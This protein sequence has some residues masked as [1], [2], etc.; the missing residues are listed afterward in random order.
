MRRRSKPRGDFGPTRM[1]EYIPGWLGV[2]SVF[3]LLPA[4]GLA[5]TRGGEDADAA[6]ADAPGPGSEGE[7]TW[8]EE[9]LAPVEPA[10]SGYHG[11]SASFESGRAGFQLEVGEVVIPYRVMAVTALPGET[12][13]LRIG[14]SGRAEHGGS[15]D[16]V[17]RD[18]DGPL[19]GAEGRWSW[20]A[21]EEP[22]VHPLRISSV[23]HADSI[24]LNVLVLHP[25]SEIRG[26]SLNGY[27]IGEYRNGGAASVEPPPGFLEVGIRERDILVSPHFTLEQFLCKQPGSPAYLAVT[28]ALVLKL[29]AILEAVN[30]AGIDA[31]TLHVMSG[32]R[33]PHYNRAI[34]NQTDLSRHLWGDAA[35]IFID[36][37]GDGMMDDLNGD[38]RVDDRD[39]EILYR[40]VESVEGAGEP[41]VHDGGLALYRTNAVRGP[42]VHVDARGHPARW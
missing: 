13:E 20:S 38:G 27:R 3:L 26:G 16:F 35:D 25:R 2:L 42:F 18:A 32:F 11:S 12:L 23:S 37:T 17:V 24:H 8:I 39:A 21:P 28:E 29:E 4:V 31:P 33:T 10:R 7:A 41:H 30:E 6:R 40:I 14:G 34:G 9:E 22:G 1:K 15:G 36:T 5:G 19:G